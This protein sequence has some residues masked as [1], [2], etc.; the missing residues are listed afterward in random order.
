MNGN[1]TLLIYKIFIDKY[2]KEIKY[3][4]NL[5]ACYVWW[6]MEGICNHCFSWTATVYPY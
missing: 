1:N 6:D 4:F 5:Y 3:L 2:N